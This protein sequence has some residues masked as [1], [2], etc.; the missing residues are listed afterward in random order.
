MD[1]T[2][3]DLLKMVSEAA[4]TGAEAAVRAVNTVDDAARPGGG[5]TE[6]TVAAPNVNLRRPQ[7]PNIGR[8]IRAAMMG[9]WKK[10]GAEL[11]KDFSEATRSL[12]PDQGKDVEYGDISWPT[13]WE[14]YYD[15]LERGA[16]KGVESEFQKMAVRALTEGTPTTSAT[17]G[18]VLTPIAFLQDQFV[19]ALTSPVA[20]LATPGV[21]IIPITTP[22]VS[23]PRESTAATASAV[24]EAGTLTA[25]DPTFSQQTFTARKIYGY[26]QF[27]NELLADANP[28][29]MAFLSRTLGRDVGLQKD[30]QF[31]AGS[32]SGANLQGIAGYSGLTTITGLPATNGQNPTY[33]TLIQMIW[34]LR[35][36]NVEPNA[37]IMHPAAAQALA[38]VKDTAGRPLFLDGSLYQLGG[39]QVPI[40]SNGAGF[41]ASGYT[42]NV[43]RGMLLGYPVFFSNQLSITQTQG[44]S[45]TATTIY[46]GNFN[47]C[48]IL[49]RLAVDIAVSPHI[50]FTTDQTAVRAIWRGAIAL[51]QPAAFVAT[52]G[53]T[54]T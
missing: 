25:S 31:L 1:I 34:G 22:V 3:D 14:S 27:S 42:P 24:A 41:Q 54:V 19:T 29:L 46:L 37:W 6:Q 26:R 4:K 17:G 49:E 39:A 47:Y 30:F 44:T 20:V 48:R 51:T 53:F 16:F 7:Y 28:A 11:E 15:V 2:Q 13:T 50:L 35:R 23:L 9:S 33:D 12:Y 43:A 36:A 32:G 38:L 52:A 5:K 18:G 21:D 8:A 10:A 40:S 45:T